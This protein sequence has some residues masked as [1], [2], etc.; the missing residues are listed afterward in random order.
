[1]TLNTLIEEMKAVNSIYP[2]RFRVNKKDGTILIGELPES[3]SFTETNYKSA[4]DAV[5]KWGM[6]KHND[7]C[8]GEE[9]YYKGLKWDE[10]TNEQRQSVIDFFK[11]N[12]NFI[13]DES[14]YER[15]FEDNRCFLE[16]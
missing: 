5:N 2:N 13:T 14:Q 12:K 9:L 16:Y 1:M 10:L 3:Y 15:L 4:L 7:E 11:N 8:F 6:L